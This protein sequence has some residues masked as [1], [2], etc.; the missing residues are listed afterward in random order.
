MVTLPANS[1][2]PPPVEIKD[3]QLPSIFVV[4]G[5]ALEFKAAAGLKT[6]TFRVSSKFPVRVQLLDAA[7]KVLFDGENKR[8]EPQTPLDPPPS[9]EDFVLPIPKAGLYT[10]SLRQPKNALS[11][12]QALP[13]TIPSVMLAFRAAKPLPSPRLYFYVPKGQKTVVMLYNDS[14]PWTPLLVDTAGDTVKVTVHDNE[15][16]FYSTVPAGQDGKIWSVA[17]IVSPNFT[18]QFLN[19]PQVFSFYHE[20]LLV[21][22]DSLTP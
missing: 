15:R 17:N 12:F 7:K 10:I 22:S 4:G 5:T 19:V 16:V 1:P 2:A 9:W 6:V 18:A 3:K 14:L 20:T 21:P 8:I 11:R 13:P